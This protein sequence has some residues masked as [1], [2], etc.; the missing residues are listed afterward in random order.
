LPV[1]LASISMRGLVATQTLM[2]LFD[3]AGAPAAMG[4][5][6]WAASGGVLAGRGRLIRVGL[7][8]DGG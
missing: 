7:A 4:Q 8:A 1:Q 2:F 3:G 5:R 6:L